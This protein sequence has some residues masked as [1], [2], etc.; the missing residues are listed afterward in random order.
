MRLALIAVFAVRTIVAQALPPPVA[1]PESLNDENSPTF[2]VSVFDAGALAGQIYKLK[3]Y[4][5]EVPNFKKMKPIGTIYTQSL[6]IPGR[7]FEEGFPGISD[8]FEWFAIDYKGRFWI[9]APGEY[10]FFLTSDDGSRLYIDG[11]KVVDNDG[12]HAEE[13]R[14]GKIKLKPGIHEIRVQYFQG[15][16]YHVALTLEVVPPDGRRRIFSTK[17]FKPPPSAY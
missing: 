12:V 9:E 7:R 2:G 8:V 3:P 14:A 11:K 13:V 5:D 4:S 6:A 17:E 1:P 10:R 16:R 15:P